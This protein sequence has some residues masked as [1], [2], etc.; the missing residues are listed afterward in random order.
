MRSSRAPG[1]LLGTCLALAVLLGACGQVAASAARPPAG[2][3]RTGAKTVAHRSPGSRRERAL[4]DAARLLGSVRLPP[5]SQPRAHEPSGD[6]H[7]LRLAPQAPADP[8]L[9][10]LHR[11]FV[12]PGGP[13]AVFAWVR[14]HVPDGAANR[15]Y[16]TA[17]SQGITDEWFVEDDWPAVTTLLDS[18]T[19]L[20]SIVALPGARSGIR[21]DA[22]VTWLPAK[23]AGELIPSGATVLTAVLSH[24]LNAGQRGHKPVTTTDPTKIAAVRAFVNRLGVFP[25]GVSHCPADFGQFL[26]VSFRKSAGARPFAVV[27]ADVA[28]CELVQVRRSGHVAKPGL[29]GFGLVG[30]VEHELGF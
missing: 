22:E 7:L 18:R 20:I 5:G 25:P 17:G 2:T 14:R 23:P 11:F 1:G 4:F 24:G 6:D 28:G 15:G 12:A 26:T 8:D 30:L 29:S 16:G 9:V 3:S 21:V 13:N 10:D 19:L 27:V